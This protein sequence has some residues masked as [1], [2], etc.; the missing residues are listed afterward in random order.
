MRILIGLGKV[1]DE[2]SKPI[3]RRKQGLQNP[4][5]THEDNLNN[6]G[7]DTKRN[8]RNKKR[9][10]LKEKLKSLIQTV[11]I[12]ILDMHVYIY[13]CICV[14]VCVCIHTYRGIN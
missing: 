6:V 2:K 13:I 1:S 7:P 5:Q 8:F 12:R 11:R 9:K 10:Y 3:H 4:C 14:C